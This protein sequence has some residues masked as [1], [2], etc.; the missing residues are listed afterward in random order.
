MNDKLVGV[1]STYVGSHGRGVPA[2][3]YHLKQIRVLIVRVRSTALKCMMNDVAVLRLG[4]RSDFRPE[5]DKTVLA[6]KVGSGR[7]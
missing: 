7:A 6:C 1:I 2:I 3:E 5:K 4:K